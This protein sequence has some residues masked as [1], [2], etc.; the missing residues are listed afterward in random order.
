MEASSGIV[1]F[2]FIARATA[3]YGTI[4]SSIYTIIMNWSLIA[5]NLMLGIG[6]AAQPL[7]SRG[8][9]SRNMEDL[10]GYR[11]IGLAFS[12][13]FGIAYL[14]IGLCFT[15][16]LVSVFATDSTELIRL[17]ERSFR[18][19]LPAF[20]IMSVGIFSGVYFQA[21]GKAA[22]SFILMVARGIALPVAFA[23][24]FSAIGGKTGLWLAMPAAEFVTSVL[25]IIFTTKYELQPKEEKEEE[26]TASPVKG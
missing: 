20:F 1:I 9:G 12:L 8:F 2:V 4:G 7:M 19:Y 23:F 21:I 26:L 22:P 10:R 3:L 13:A 25:G 14:I 17:A 5:V 16:P 24:L 6:Q 15:D 11:Q 18:L